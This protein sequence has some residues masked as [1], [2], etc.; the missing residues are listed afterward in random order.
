MKALESVR[1]EQ[2]IVSAKALLIHKTMLG[3]GRQ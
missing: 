3:D 1:E 2:S